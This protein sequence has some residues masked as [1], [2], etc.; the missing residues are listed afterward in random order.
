ME[1]AIL[2]QKW[3]DDMLDQAFEYLRE[4]QKEF[5]VQQKENHS[6]NQKQMGRLATE[7]RMLDRR[8]WIAYGGFAVLIILLNHYWR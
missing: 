2:R 1:H 6:A 3:T 5:V 7:L 8:Y 4:S